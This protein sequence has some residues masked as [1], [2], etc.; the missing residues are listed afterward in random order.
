M[1]LYYLSSSVTA[2]EKE[3]AIS[4]M[5]IL[6]KKEL[7]KDVNLTELVFHLLKIRNEKKPTARGMNWYFGIPNAIPLWT[8]RQISTFN[9][10]YYVLVLQLTYELL[11]LIAEEYPDSLLYDYETQI[12]DLFFHTLE[13]ILLNQQE[14]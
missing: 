7:C 14:V 9:F 3:N 2:K 5:Q 11:G 13:S 10:E 8:P 4:I 6:V 12:R 1:V